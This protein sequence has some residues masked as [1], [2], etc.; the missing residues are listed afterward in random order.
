MEHILVSLEGNISSGK[1]NMIEYLKTKDNNDFTII[2]EPILL[3]QNVKTKNLLK[4]MYMNNKNYIFQQYALLTRYELQQKHISQNVI[5]ERSFLSSQIFIQNSYEMN[6]LDE[7]EKYILDKHLHIFQNNSNKLTHI[8]YLYTNPEI[9][10]QRIQIR[11]R[12]EENNITLQY[13]QNLHYQHETHLS[14]LN[15]P[16]I[17]IDANQTKEEIKHSY[18]KTIFLLNH[19]EEIS[20]IQFI[21]GNDI[22]YQYTFNNKTQ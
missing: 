16:I 4:D 13:L 7:T 18:D 10:L 5:M 14:K 15:I 6:L 1:S 9:A 20:P 12:L 19:T 8:I 22:E 11:N 17:I 21:K 3:W 2:E